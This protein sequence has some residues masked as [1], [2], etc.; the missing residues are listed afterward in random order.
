MGVT[1]EGGGRI[2]SA[3]HTCGA[4]ATHEPQPVFAVDLPS[5]SNQHCRGSNTQAAGT[6]SGRLPTTVAQNFT[7]CAHPGTCRPCGT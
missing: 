2:R 6:M 1:G 5:P 7:Y 4:L 3:S